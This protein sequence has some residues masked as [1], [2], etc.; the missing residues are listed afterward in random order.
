VAEVSYI[1]AYKDGRRQVQFALK[2]I[3]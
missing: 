3:F 2:F 1:S